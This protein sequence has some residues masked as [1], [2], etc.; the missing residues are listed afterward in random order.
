MLVELSKREIEAPRDPPRDKKGSPVPYELRDTTQTGLLLRIEPGGTRSWFF[1]YRL[2][3]RRTR[4]LLGRY[5]GLSPKAAQAAAKIAAGDVA[6]GID[7]SARK[8][9]ER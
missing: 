7:I 3:G 8:K 1:E 2:K 6:K 5:P 9:A 4:L